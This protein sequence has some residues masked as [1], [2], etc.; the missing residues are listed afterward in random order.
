ML[1]CLLALE[2]NQLLSCLTFSIEEHEGQCVWQLSLACNGHLWDEED[3]LGRRY[4][5]VVEARDFVVCH[6]YVDHYPAQRR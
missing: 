1:A 6:F 3:C 2:M 4:S 5:F